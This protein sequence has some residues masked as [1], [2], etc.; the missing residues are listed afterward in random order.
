MVWIESHQALVDFY[1]KKVLCQNNLG[2]PVVTEWFKWNVPLCF[3]SMMKVK[4]FMSKGC[5]IF[6]VKEVSTNSK[7]HAKLHMVLIEFCICISFEVSSVTAG[8]RI[9][10]PFP[11]NLDRSHIQDTLLYDHTWTNLSHYGLINPNVSPQ[12]ATLIF[13][14][15]KDG[16]ISICIDYRDLNKETITIWYPMPHIDEYLSTKKDFNIV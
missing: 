6:M 11:W 7:P 5:R 4:K 8:R 12:G 16:T 2:D 1:K 14:N 9:F 10:S 3:I 15:N 13:V